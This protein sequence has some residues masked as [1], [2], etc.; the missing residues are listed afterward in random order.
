MRLSS[1]HCAEF[2]GFDFVEDADFAGLAEGVFRI[3]EIFVGEAVDVIIGAFFGDLDDFAADL[4][5]AVRIFGI[6]DGERD[7]RIATHVEIFDAATRGIHTDMFAVEVAPDR[8]DLRAAVFH[9]CA[10]IGEGFLAEQ[11]GIFFESCVGHADLRGSKVN[12]AVHQDCTTSVVIN[13]ASWN[14]WK[15]SAE[16]ASRN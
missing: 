6:D 7:A 4:E 13:A 9:E 15:G 10:E 2:L 3:A 5:V 1:A 12:E 16:A 11:I 14:L 8:S